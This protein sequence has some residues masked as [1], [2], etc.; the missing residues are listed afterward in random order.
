M[1]RRR[2]TRRRCAARRSDI[3]LG[4]AGKNSHVRHFEMYGGGF[5]VELENVSLSWRDGR[6]DDGRRQ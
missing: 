1:V 2:P 3:F 6:A 4:G 5:G